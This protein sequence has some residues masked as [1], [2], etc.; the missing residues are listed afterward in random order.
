MY[1]HIYI[2]IYID[3]LFVALIPSLRHP[4]LSRPGVEKILHVYCKVSLG[5]P[6]G[7]KLNPVI[8]ILE[9]FGVFLGSILALYGST[10]GAIWAYV[11]SVKPASGR[12]LPSDPFG[13]GA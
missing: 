2:Y 4:L 10:W 11:G 7:C 6:W 1:I 9:F 8:P 13:C 12:T 3:F 5:T